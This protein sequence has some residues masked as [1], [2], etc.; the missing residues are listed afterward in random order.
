MSVAAGWWCRRDRAP[1]RS[2]DRRGA[3]RS[4]PTR[5]ISSPLRPLSG[6]SQARPNKVTA[7]GRRVKAWGCT[8]A[9]PAGTVRRDVSEKEHIHAHHPRD[10]RRPCGACRHPRCRRADA[11]TAAMGRMSARPPSQDRAGPSCC[12]PPGT[13]CRT[14][15]RT[16]PECWP[17]WGSTCWPP[18]FIPSASARAR[19]RIGRPGS[20]RCWP[21]PMARAPC[22][23]PLS[24]PLGHRAPIP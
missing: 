13:G 5:R 1:R 21:I 18:I 11:L 14:M 16:A 3:R 22:C 10:R 12:C 24:M 2:R 8:G 9:P 19:W 7:I 4:A 23:A 15:S 6:L 20:K 17:K